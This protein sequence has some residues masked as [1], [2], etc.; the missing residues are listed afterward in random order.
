MIPANFLIEL[1]LVLQVLAVLMKSGLIQ[2]IQILS[3][4]LLDQEQVIGIIQLMKEQLQQ[5]T[6]FEIV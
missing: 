6:L 3:M 2:M 5:I 4:Y 1:D